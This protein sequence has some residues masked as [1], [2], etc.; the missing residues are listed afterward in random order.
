M[1]ALLDGFRGYQTHFKGLN[2]NH[3]NK[4]CSVWLHDLTEDNENAVMGYKLNDAQ[5]IKHDLRGD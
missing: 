1:V 5:K 2:E 4:F 3:S